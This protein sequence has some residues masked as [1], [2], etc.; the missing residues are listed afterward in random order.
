MTLPVR[1]KTD[2]L[3]LSPVQQLLFTAHKQACPN[4]YTEEHLHNQTWVGLPHLLPLGSVLPQLHRSE[5]T[6]E[7]PVSLTLGA[8]TICQCDTAV[9]MSALSDALLQ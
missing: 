4:K 7:L 3:F 5:H 9:E 8:G 1:C 2:L 6:L